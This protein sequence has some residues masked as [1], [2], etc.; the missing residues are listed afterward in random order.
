M[1]NNKSDI[2]L[3]IL[4]AVITLVALLQDYHVE[5]YEDNSGVISWEGARVSHCVPG[6][7]CGEG[8]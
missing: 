5:Y 7:L 3:A 4:L 8:E 6:G 2:A 1:R